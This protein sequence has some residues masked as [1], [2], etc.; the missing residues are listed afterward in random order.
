M[1]GTKH[2]LLCAWGHISLLSGAAGISPFLWRVTAWE[3]ASQPAVSI[4]RCVTG[5][6]KPVAQKEAFLLPPTLTPTSR[7]ALGTLLVS[8][9]ISGQACAGFRMNEGTNE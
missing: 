7:T 1:A 6:G 8:A 5:K 4:V 3:P 9:P 2:R